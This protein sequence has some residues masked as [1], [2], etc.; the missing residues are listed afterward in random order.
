MGTRGVAKGGVG[1]GVCALR[2][3]RLLCFIDELRDDLRSC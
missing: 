3:R 1:V 2:T